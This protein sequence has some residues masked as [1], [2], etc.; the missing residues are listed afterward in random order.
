MNKPGFISHA[1]PQGPPT[2]DQV[3]REI[4]WNLDEVGTV[5]ITPWVQDLQKPLM[6]PNTRWFKLKVK[7]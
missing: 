7:K 2:L 3:W 5:K 4:K 1:I 6:L